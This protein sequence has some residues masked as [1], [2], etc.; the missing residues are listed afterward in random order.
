VWWLLD[1]LTTPRLVTKS[2]ANDLALQQ[3]VYD[4]RKY[5]TRLMRAI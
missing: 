1:I 5:E 2:S 4:V 3:N